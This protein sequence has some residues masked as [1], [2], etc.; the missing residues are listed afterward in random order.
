MSV[1]FNNHS[2]HTYNS[3]PF[4]I[5]DSVLSDESKPVEIPTKRWSILEKLER[6]H[7]CRVRSV[8]DCI[9]IINSRCLLA[10]I[11]LFI[12]VFLILI[13]TNTVFLNV[14]N[15]QSRYD[16]II[17]GAGP[18][19]SI[20]AAK[21]VEQGANVLLL[22]AGGTTQYDLGG[23]DYFG[24]AVTRFDIPLFWASTSHYD[25]YRWHGLNIPEILLAKGLGG[26][27]AHNAMLYVRALASDID[28][29]NLPNWK[30]EAFLDSYLSI[31]DYANDKGETSIPSYH[32]QGGILKVSR[33]TFIDSMAPEFISS[34]IQYGIKFTEDFNDPNGREGVGMYDFNI[35]DGIRDSAARVFLG[36]LIK[37][38]PKNFNLQINCQVKRILLNPIHELHD[39]SPQYHAYG[40]EYEQNGEL[41]T[42]LLSIDRITTVGRK[43]ENVRSIIVAG[44]AIMSPKLLLASGIG[45]DNVLKDAKIDVKV[46][47][48]WVG[49]NLQDHP[50]VGLLV[51]LNPE[52]AAKYPSAYSTINGWGSYIDAI[53]KSLSGI[54]VSKEDIGIL[55]SPG[56]SAGAFLISPFAQNNIPD[57]QL[58][59][60]P[61]FGEPHLVKRYYKGTNSSII[62]NIVIEGNEM[63]ITVAL[64]TPDARYEITLNNTDPI[65]S[66]PVFNIPKGRHNYLSDRDAER[67]AWG[68]QQVR[69]ILKTP[70]LSELT[71]DIIEPSNDVNNVDLTNWVRYNSYCNSHW[72]GSA[73]MGSS[74]ENSAINENLQVHNVKGLYVTDASAIPIIPN[75]NVHSTVVVVACIA[76][77]IIIK[78]FKL[79]S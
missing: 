56:I 34:A 44:G 37:N 59:V 79:K 51:K 45:P 67:L 4:E 71:N 11:M 61:T 39:G 30:W 32:K 8:H 6:R 46:Q 65:N 47:N 64:L 52:I 3:V 25:E 7:Y 23:K 74:V 28:S 36:P 66:P 68:I 22:E 29:W 57:I 15:L 43:F 55:G 27:G 31:E 70:P 2:K 9:T 58:T 53:N 63:L 17:I 62:S 54:S 13:F 72:V 18:A 35:R 19:G 69:G 60:F 14:I 48:E 16:F 10:S 40:V 75:G 21:L 73:K 50:A 26:S 20:V 24:G 78:S 42:A 41:K 38:Q 49:K 33:S 1:P 77:D 76:A 5:A 12:F